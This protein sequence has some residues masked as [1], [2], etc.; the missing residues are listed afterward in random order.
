[1]LRE[2]ANSN[3]NLPVEHVI[4]TQESQKTIEVIDESKKTDAP[5]KTEEIRTDS[6]LFTKRE[7]V[8]A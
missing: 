4:P 8:N 5:G 3:Y 1:M 7:I 2:Y 6:L